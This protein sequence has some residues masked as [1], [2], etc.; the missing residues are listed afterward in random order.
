MMESMVKIARENLLRKYREKETKNEKKSEDKP[1]MNENIK[2]EIK[3][4]K[5]INRAK[6]NTENEEEKRALL[7]K[8]EEQKAKINNLI[9][10]EIE[11][12]EIKIT[13]EIKESDNKGKKMWESIYILRGKNKKDEK[14]KIFSENREELD[15]VEAG[16]RVEEFWKY[17][18]NICKCDLTKKWKKEDIQKMLKD[19]EEEKVIKSVIKINE[20]LFFVEE[21][22]A[23]M[24][25]LEITQE[26]VTDV[27][28]RL[29]NKKAAGPDL[30]T[31]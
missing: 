12:Y 25:K 13:K 14:D 28:E 5:E 8:W 27:I 9:R 24:K 6:R 10:K 29:K 2:K 22:I 19:T 3:K 21:K 4:R 11:D 7:K 17:I 30:L 26:H 15:Q 1:W 18:F 31:P 20:Q 16:N 23:P